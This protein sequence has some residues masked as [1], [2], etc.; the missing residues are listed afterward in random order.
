MRRTAMPRRRSSRAN[1]ARSKRLSFEL[2]LS[3]LDAPIAFAPGFAPEPAIDPDAL[4]MFEPFEAAPAAASADD[5]A[6]DLELAA[7][8]P[9]EPLI[10]S[11]TPTTWPADGIESA[12]LP[13]VESRRD[14]PPL[15]SAFSVDVLDPAIGQ[16]VEGDVREDADQPRDRAP[17]AHAVAAEAIAADADSEP[18]IDDDQVKRVGP[19]RIG[20]PLFNIY[21]NEADELSRR[22]GTE[23]AE[24][25]MELHR[26]IGETPIALAHSLA[27]S[28][29]TVGFA[30]LSQLARALEHALSRSQAIGRGTAEEARLFGDAADEI[31]RLLHQF[32]AGFL[33]QPAPEL[34]ARLAD[35]EL[36]SALRLD[37]ATAAAESAPADLA[38]EA[39]P[40]H[41]SAALP[42]LDVAGAQPSEPPRPVE[43]PPLAPPPPIDE[44]Q[45]WVPPPP[46]E[47]PAPEPPSRATAVGRTAGAGRRA[48]SRRCRTGTAALDPALSRRSAWRR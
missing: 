22:L 39:E 30:D 5:A 16:G 36:S 48:A 31:R 26:P 44:P 13:L 46:V 11:L 29:A 23:L 2:D 15:V 32:A 21:L 19:L 12:P 38:E 27:G 3:A 1:P 20:I 41:D 28:S 25:A 33:K 45:P 7:E 17:G 47:P 24:W 10:E 37:A 14:E 42:L 6:L 18:G 35:H 4:A 34:F 40:S 8:P 9:L 43:E